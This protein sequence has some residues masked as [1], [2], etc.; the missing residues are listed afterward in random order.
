MYISDFLK[1][2]QKSWSGTLVNCQSLATSLLRIKPHISTSLFAAEWD[3]AS[4]PTLTLQMALI[5]PLCCSLGTPSGHNSEP[6]KKI[7]FILC[8]SSCSPNLLT[9][10]RLKRISIKFD[11]SEAQKPRWHFCFNL[12]GL[13]PFLFH[14]PGWTVTV[15]TAVDC[16]FEESV[17]IS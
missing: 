10:Q 13:I 3:M 1:R 14:L 16:C 2:P 17:T 12:W 8:F 4:E 6:Q 7:G 9:I 11:W 5:C 15:T